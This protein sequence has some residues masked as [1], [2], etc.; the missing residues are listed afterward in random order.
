MS[1]ITGIHCWFD[2]NVMAEP[3]LALVDQP[4]HWVF[5]KTLLFQTLEGDEA[6]FHKPLGASTTDSH[7]QY[8]QLVVSASHGWEERPRQ[9]I[10]DLCL[11]T[12]RVVLPHSRRA[13]LT[14]A[15]V[16]RESAATFSVE[17][18]CDRWRPGQRTSVPGLFVAGDW[19]LTGW[20][21]TME[22]AVR[23]GYMAAEAI[24]GQAGAP[25]SVLQPELRA[26]L[27]AAWLGRL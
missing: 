20:P 2:Q 6:S 4:I 21:A 19:T 1:P 24:G 9:E 7:R 13:R 8:L 14:E 22:G 27:L 3:Y 23:S 15:I 17:P 11:D 18:G 16:L 12:L 5:N 25:F 10:V 26:G